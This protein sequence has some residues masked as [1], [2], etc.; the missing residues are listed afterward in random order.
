MHTGF[1]VCPLK[2]HMPTLIGIALDLAKQLSSKQLVI[3]CNQQLWRQALAAA[4]VPLAA[5]VKAW[6]QWHALNGQGCNHAG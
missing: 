4:V 6:Q 5:V 2:T 1:T 3:T